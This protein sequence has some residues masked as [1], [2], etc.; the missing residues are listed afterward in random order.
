MFFLSQLL[1][2]HQLTLKHLKN[3]AN[4]KRVY[5]WII[6]FK[7]EDLILSNNKKTESLIKRFGF[8]AFSDAGGTN[9]YHFPNL[10]VGQSPLSS[11]LADP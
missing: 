9:S 8:V 6:D 7:N 1:V 5:H 11:D 4:L 2:N 10:V 3:G